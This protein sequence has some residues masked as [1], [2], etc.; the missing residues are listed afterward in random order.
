MMNKSFLLFIQ[1]FSYQFIY[2]YQNNTTPWR[3]YILNAQNSSDCYDHC[4]KTQII[5]DFKYWSQQDGIHYSHFE[6]AL[7]FGIHYQILDGKVY[8]QNDCLFSFRCIGVEYFLKQIAPELNNTEF[9]LNVHDHPKA[10]KYRHPFPIFSFSRTSNE[11]DILYP[12]WSFW[13]GG[14]AIQTEPTGLG[15]WDLKRSTIEKSRQKWNWER[16]VN[17]AFFRGSRTSSE[18]DPL[19]WLSREKPHLVKADYT[20]NQAWKSPKDTLDQAPAEIITLEDH[21]QYKY[22]FNF[23]GVAASFRLRHLFLCESLVFHVGEEWTEFF[24]SELIPWY[25]YIPVSVSLNEVE[26]LL[27]FAKENDDIVRRIAENGRLF[28]ENHLRMEDVFD[29]WRTLL[30][31]Y[32]GLINWTVPNNSSLISIG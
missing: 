23:R 25:H 31:T 6:R 9:V 4:Y 19:I 17:L 15:R 16:K 18:R 32:T 24:Y 12:A 11:M 3:Q 21:C 30:H 2:S 27:V 14:P 8:R 13:A 29:Y 1:I 22:L 5:S 10:G 20:K 7:K 26:E 28:I